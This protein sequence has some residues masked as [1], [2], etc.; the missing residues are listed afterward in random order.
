MSTPTLHTNDDGRWTRTT[1]SQVAQTMTPGTLEQDGAV[2]EN[3]G[4]SNFTKQGRGIAKDKIELRLRQIIKCE[5]NTT[6]VW[7]VA[8]RSLARREPTQLGEDR[9]TPENWGAS[10]FGHQLL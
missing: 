2:L 10:K 1:A 6:I 4:T 9:K 8:R 5:E 3:R 7:G